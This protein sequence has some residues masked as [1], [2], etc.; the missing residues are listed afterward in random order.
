MKKRLFSKIM[1]IMVVSV[2]GI[3]FIMS[4]QAQA[5]ESDVGVSMFVTPMSQRILLIP[6]ETYEGV[7]TVANSANAQKNLNYLVKVGSYK[8]TKNNETGDDYGPVDVETRGERNTMV[9]WVTVD[10]EGGE[11]E[12]NGT[13]QITFKID[14]PENA[15]AGAQYASILVSQV[16]DSN[17]KKD[18]VIINNKYQLVSAIFANVSGETI[19]KGQIIGNDVPSFLL[20]NKLE[21]SSMVRNEGNIYTD[22]EYTLQVWPM[23]SDEEICTNEEKPIT[24][25]VLPDTERYNVQNCDLPSIGLFN[26]KQVVKIFGETSTTTKTVIACPLWLLFI[27]IFLVVAIIIWIVMK[28]RNRK[29]NT[30]KSEE[31]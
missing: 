12:P 19:E 2:A 8:L 14:V 10:K 23:F 18:D 13:D 20:N 4:G 7:I 26:V 30:K 5:E 28:I 11:I 25:L 3:G 16:D 24:S 9:D 21:A 15:P 27:I 29:K 17:N 1:A 6:G 31:Q 22:A